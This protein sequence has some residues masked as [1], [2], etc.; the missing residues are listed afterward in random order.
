MKV[1]QSVGWWRGGRKNIPGGMIAEVLQCEIV[2]GFN[3]VTF[4]SEGNEVFG[5]V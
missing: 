4:Y 1:D 2:K 5:K 3:N